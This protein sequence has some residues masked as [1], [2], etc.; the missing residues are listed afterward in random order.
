MSPSP[1]EET[2]PDRAI[3]SLNAA[4]GLLAHGEDEAVDKADTHRADYGTHANGED[5]MP[6]EVVAVHHAVLNEGDE[7]HER[8]NEWIDKHEAELAVDAHALTM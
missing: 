2:A 4:P 3:T 6:G 8:V 5:G 1:D 7:P